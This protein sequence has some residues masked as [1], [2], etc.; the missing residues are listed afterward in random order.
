MIGRVFFVSGFLSI[1]VLMGIACH[2][3]NQ[4]E[5]FSSTHLEAGLIERWK[6]DILFFLISTSVG[7]PITKQSHAQQTAR[8]L[9]KHMF[10]INREKD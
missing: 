1:F 2:I 6:P 8:L 10:Y 7:L 3:A 4:V 5:P 9:G